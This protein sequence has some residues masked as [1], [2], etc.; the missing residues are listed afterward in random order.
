[1]EA[2]EE[3]IIDGVDGR[4]N[5]ARLLL[6]LRS[7]RS[8][9]NREK[10]NKIV[11]AKQK[12]QMQISKQAQHKKLETEDLIV[13]KIEDEMG[14]STSRKTASKISTADVYSAILHHA[15]GP[16][17]HPIS[18]GLAKAKPTIGAPIPRYLTTTT[19]STIFFQV[20]LPFM[21]TAWNRVTILE[22]SYSFSSF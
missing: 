15:P 8:N 14:Y 22:S 20:T 2:E 6:P 17:T 12:K 21:S 3:N 4:Q 7:R 19:P 9:R 11:K 10:M 1:M 18:A 16:L 13:D 5:E